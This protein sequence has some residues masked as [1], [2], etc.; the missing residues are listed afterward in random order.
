M[1]DLDLIRM[2]HT[3]LQEIKELA[4]QIKDPQYRDGV[5]PTLTNHLIVEDILLDD[6]IDEMTRRY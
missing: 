4:E 1:E 3:K 5:R 6:E 2:I